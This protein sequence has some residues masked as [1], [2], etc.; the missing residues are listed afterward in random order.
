MLK[1]QQLK[2][3]SSEPTYSSDKCNY[4][5]TTFEENFLIWKKIG[6]SR[7]YHVIIV[8]ILWSVGLFCCAS[9]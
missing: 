5:K 4:E 2:T 8:G 3:I 9:G 7:P 1:R 6:T